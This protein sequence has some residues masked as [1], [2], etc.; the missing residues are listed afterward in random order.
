MKLKSFNDAELN[1]KKVLVR[2]DF[3]V[4]LDDNGK[5]TDITRIKAHVSTITELL[6]KGAKVALVSHL[7]RPKG[8]VVPKYSLEPVAEELEKQISKKVVFISDCTGEKVLEKTRDW[9][10]DEILLL[11]NVR[12][13]AEEEKNDAAFA[14]KLAEPFDAF[15]MDAFSA[16][17]RAHASTNAITKILPSYSGNLITKE[18]KMLSI[19]RDN[20]VKP[21]VL[22]LGG[23]KVSDKIAVIENMLEKV[24]TILIGG[25]M[26]F[27]FLKTMGYEIGK[28][29]CETEKLDF[30]KAML[31][32]AKELGVDIV[33]PTDVIA[34]AE[35]KNDCKFS[36]VSVNDI[37]AESMG[38]DI[39]T[40]T[41]AKFSEIIRNAKSVLWN[42]PMG[43]FEMSNFANGSKAVA[44]ALVAATKENEA[45]TVVGGGDSA[46][47]ITMF[48][49]EKSVSH[50]STGGGASLEF[51]EGKE[52][53]GIVP[54]VIE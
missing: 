53:P 28:S 46:A 22:I 4:P 27:T 19:V 33:L 16:S 45:I 11:E 50:V 42:G 32:R 37:P 39:G 5:V 51:F 30:A 2:V 48:G 34:A 41:S 44:E 15:V 18:I 29:L 10:A 47:A 1:G 26:A 38:L 9:N 43:V 17:H 52:L 31:D 21:F 3:N 23:S 40:E 20:P 12:Y 8:Q 35:F 6:S 24:D 14:E 13:Y 36:C 7:G 25:G 54:F 49:L